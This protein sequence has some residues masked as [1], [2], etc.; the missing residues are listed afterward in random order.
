MAI[1][2]NVE[3][4]RVT[5][6]NACDLGCS[7]NGRIIVEPDVAAQVKSWLRELS[8]DASL[9]AVI[10]FQDT[11]DGTAVQPN[12]DS[13]RD[14]CGADNFYGSVVLVASGRRLLDLQELRQ[15]VWS[16]ALSRGARSFCYV[17]TRGSAE[18]A[19]KMSIE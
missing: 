17:D 2:A 15:G 11:D 10:Y 9:R 3:G 18:E 4:G 16:E 1:E 5:L 6:L 14:I 12:I 7:V 8:P 13:F 19:I